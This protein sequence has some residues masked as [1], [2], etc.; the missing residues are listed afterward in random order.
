MSDVLRVNFNNMCMFVLTDDGSEAWFLFDRRHSPVLDLRESTIKPDDSAIEEFSLVDWSVSFEFPDSE[1]G[2]EPTRLGGPYVSH[3]VN[4]EQVIPGARLETGWKPNVGEFP[5]GMTSRVILLAGDLT[6]TPLGTTGGAKRWQIGENVLQ[7]MTQD[8]KWERPITDPAYIV[9][10][11]NG[12]RQPLRWRLH[13]NKDGDAIVSIRSKEREDTELPKS[14]GVVFLDEFKAFDLAI[15]LPFGTEIPIP[16][17]YWPE[18]S[19]ET[20][21][22]GGPCPIGFLNLQTGRS[23]L[24]L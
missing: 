16:F 7:R 20:D 1:K 8:T 19:K 22:E 18:Y 6:P 23:L 17:T 9:L 13:R 11:H 10:T 5:E 4:L 21:P 15:R 14:H 24:P 12:K 2:M 3:L